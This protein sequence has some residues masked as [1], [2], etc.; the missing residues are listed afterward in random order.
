MIKSVDSTVTASLLL[1]CKIS[2]SLSYLMNYRNHVSSGP[3]D[4]P[5]T[6]NSEAGSGV[7]W[8]KDPGNSFRVR[9]RIAEYIQTTSTTESGCYR[10]QPN[11]FSCI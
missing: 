6:A 11:T 3:C 4:M 1:S 8:T 5:I 2:S 7:S 10:E 9:A